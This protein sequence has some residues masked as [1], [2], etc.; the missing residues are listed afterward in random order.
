MATKPKRP[1]DPFQLAKIIGD[2]STG[3]AEDQDPNAGKNPAAVALGK[4]GGVK[5]GSA[6]AEKLSKERRVEIAKKAALARWPK[7][8]QDA[9]SGAKRAKKVKIVL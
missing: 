9:A 2:I 5:G 4:L 8:A 7:N 1:R 3:Q 6:R